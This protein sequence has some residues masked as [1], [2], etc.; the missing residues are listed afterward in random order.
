MKIKLSNEEHY[1]IVHAAVEE[2]FHCG[3]LNRIKCYEKLREKFPDAGEENLRWVSTRVLKDI[4]RE[5]VNKKEELEN[6][7]DKL[8]KYLLKP[9]KLS[10]VSQYF[11]IDKYQILGYVTEINSI[12]NYLISVTAE[13]GDYILAVSKER[14]I[15]KRE[16]T[17]YIGEVK[18][19]KFM[20]ISDSHIGGIYEQISFL[21]YL[22]DLAVAKGIDTVYHIGD[23]SDGYY[24]NRPE[25]IF[26]LHKHGA[27]EQAE[28]IIR[29]YPKRE[30]VTT[31]FILG[32]HDETHI[33]NGGADIGK[34]I[35][36][37][38]VDM[39]YLG[40]G[41]ARVWLTPYCSMELLHPLDGSAYALS[42]SGQ[43]YMDGLS[44]GDK[45]HILLVGHHHKAMYFV[46]RNIHYFEVPSTCM[47]S[48]WEKRKRISNTSGAWILEVKVDDEGTLTEVSPTSIIQYKKVPDDYKQYK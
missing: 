18:S 40:I 28:Y 19:K 41:H 38:R 46:Y 9:R 45:P 24:R 5:L 31:Y 32:N 26:S 29:N 14:S 3:K 44:G 10:I 21:N 7:K 11:N 12:G 48:N 35:S 2:T 42:Y 43:K 37:N 39:V 25:H 15:E 30:G 20:V 8:I 36:D 34:R 13:D 17:H 22:Y 33:R 6:V 1:K 47:Q 16:Y 27:D 23:I 4:K